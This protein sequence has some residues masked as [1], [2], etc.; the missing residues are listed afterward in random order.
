MNKLL[1]SLFALSFSCI[2]VSAMADNM[3]KESKFN[4]MDTNKDGM[5]SKDEYMKAQEMKWMKMKKTSSGMVD[6]KM[7]EDG[8][9]LS[10]EGNIHKPDGVSN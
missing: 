6:P 7:M 9:A 1:I 10:M 3:A 5:I 2:S 4:M 8:N